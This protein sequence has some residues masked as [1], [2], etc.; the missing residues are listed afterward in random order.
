V[1]GNRT[2]LAAVACRANRT[3]TTV[4]DPY[5][6]DGGGSPS[7]EFCSRVFDNDTS[8]KFVN[9]GGAT[10]SDGA[11]SEG[12]VGGINFSILVD[13]K[14]A[15]TIT[16]VG[17]TTAND[18]SNRDVTRFEL[19]GSSSSLNSGWNLVESSGALSPPTSRFTDYSDVS[20]DFP[21]SYR[22]YKIKF[23]Q[24]R[25]TV[26]DPIV[27]LSELRFYGNQDSAL[28]VTY[29]S[30]GGSAITNGSTL[31][32]GSIGASPGTPTRTG[33]S[34]GGWSATIGGP[35]ITFPYAHGQS[36]NFTLFALWSS[37]LS[38]ATP[39]S[40]L[41]GTFNSPFTP[42]TISSSGGSGGNTFAVA[43]GTLPAGLTINSST[44]VISG[45]PSIVGTSTLTVSVTDSSTATRTTSN[46]TLTISKAT[47]T[48]SISSLGTSAKT[49]PYSQALN[50]TTSVSA[51]TG[52]VTYSV[53]NDTALGCAL[54]DTASATATLTATT[55]GSCLIRAIVATDSNYESATSTAATFTF[56]KANQPSLLISSD[57]TVAFGQTLSLLTSGGD[58]TGTVTYLVLSST[59]ANLCSISGS[60]LTS[61]GVGSCTVTATKASDDNY[62]A[63]TS[64]VTTITITT[65]SATATISFTSTTFTFG[66]TNPITVTTSVAGVVRFSANGKLIKNCKAR[67]TTLTGPFTAT[68]SYRPDTRRPLTITAVLTPTDTRFATRTSTS[69][70]FLVGRRTGGRG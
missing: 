61:T 9:W 56:S 64:S 59:P 46:F 4:G 15:W 38:I 66:I 1:S 63:E 62:L 20:V 32:N 14:I 3:I 18:F 21:G 24:T 45:T 41:A 30:Q 52:A 26:P 54:S 22:Y 10:Q 49:F 47:R 5:D 60:S 58:G 40:G 7:N 34:F 57:T 39:T 6:I 8:T 68:C 13:L 27:A 2:P 12:G 65:G 37:T 48:I 36:S 50:I 17:L 11:N 23:T 16:K 53:S 55:S 35:A 25:S 42:L 67:S 51:G 70:T 28:T 31:A 29:D 19:Y 44:G 43:S 33:Y 69:G